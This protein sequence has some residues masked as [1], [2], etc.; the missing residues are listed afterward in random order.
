MRHKTGRIICVKRMHTSP[1]YAKK[2]INRLNHISDL[3]GE[4]IPLIQRIRTVNRK[5]IEHYE[6]D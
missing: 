2:S 4:M 1:S 5:W 6:K 3:M